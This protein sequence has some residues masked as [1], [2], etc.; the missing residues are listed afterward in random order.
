MEI[1]AIAVAGAGVLVCDSEGGRLY[2]GGDRRTE[3]GQG[4]GDRAGQCQ[5]VGAGCL[6]LY[7]QGH[8]T[9]EG[10]QCVVVEIPAGGA[11]GDV[12]LLCYG[13]D[14]VGE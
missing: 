1:S 12:H 8:F 11:F 14:S 2:E 10:A 9:G 13:S 3:G 4:H 7:V 6:F 5:Q